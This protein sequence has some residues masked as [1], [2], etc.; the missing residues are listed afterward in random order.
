MQH[1]KHLQPPLLPPPGSLI[2]KVNNGVKILEELIWLKPK[3][4]TAHSAA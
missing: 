4:P 1:F 3:F 2:Y